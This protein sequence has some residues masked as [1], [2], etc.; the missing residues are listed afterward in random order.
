MLH[1]DFVLGWENIL[2]EET[3]GES[4]GYTVDQTS[5]GTS[6]G[7]G[8]HNVQFFVLD[9]DGTVLHALPGFWHPEDL[10]EELS[11]GLDMASLWQDPRHSQAEK[12][13]IFSR[14]QISFLSE[15]SPATF[16]RSAWQGFDRKN[17][18]GRLEERGDRDTFARLPS[19][20]IALNEKGDPRL[21]PVNVVIHERLADR[22]FLAYKDFDTFDFADYGRLYY[23]NNKKV[24]G[25]GSIFLTPRRQEKYEVQAAKVKAREQKREAKKL[26]KSS[27]RK[28]KKNVG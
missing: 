3:V 28:M 12:R 23:D 25:V 24:D 17:E 22:P 10:A 11:F 2:H 16:A 5:V 21:K 13:E 6:N 4:H 7:A 15:Q 1:S 14:R 19:G 9:G 27:R 20:E 18:L 8:P 26:Q